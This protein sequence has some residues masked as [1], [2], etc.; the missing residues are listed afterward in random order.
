M[1]DIKQYVKER[2]EMLMKRSPEELRKFIQNHSEC[3][4]GRF[5]EAIAKAPKNILEIT[6]HHGKFIKI[7]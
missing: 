4:P 5:V 7:C 1:I 3:F 6:L 2:D